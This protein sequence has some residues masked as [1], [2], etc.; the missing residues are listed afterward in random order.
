MLLQGKKTIKNFAN[1]N[2]P[3]KNVDKTN[4]KREKIDFRYA[5]LSFESIEL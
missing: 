4:A 5:S 2:K 1:R 3:N